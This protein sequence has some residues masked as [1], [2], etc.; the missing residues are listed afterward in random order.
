MFNTETLINREFF[1]APDGPDVLKNH[2]ESFNDIFYAQN[3]RIWRFNMC[4][5]GAIRIFVE[6]NS[7]APR[8]PSITEDQWKHRNRVFGKFGFDGP[9]NYYR[10][11]LN[12]ET[13]EDDKSEFGR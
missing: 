10:I 2:I 12:G 9:L 3:G 8:L 4:P 13:T 6:S 11:N 7:R 5:E 1:T